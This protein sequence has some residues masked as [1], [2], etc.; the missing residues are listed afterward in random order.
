MDMHATLI[1]AYYK[2]ELETISLTN[3][4]RQRGW[5]GTR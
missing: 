2:R 1:F 3:L 5:L 4:A